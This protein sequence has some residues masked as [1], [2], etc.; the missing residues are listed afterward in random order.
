MSDINKSIKSR[1]WQHSM[2]KY[3]IICFND[4]MN[5]IIMQIKDDEKI[6]WL[7]SLS[8]S[9]PIKSVLSIGLFV[10]YINQI[11]QWSMKLCDIDLSEVNTYMN[12]DENINTKK[13][14]AF[15]EKLFFLSFFLLIFGCRHT[16]NISSYALIIISLSSSFHHHSCLIIYASVIGR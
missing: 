15:N 13:F 5:E 4:E 1:K 9:F 6:W 3:E 10:V 12:V 14:I 8:H 16:D 7:L 11:G 2:L